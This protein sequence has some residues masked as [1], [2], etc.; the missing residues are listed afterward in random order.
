[1]TILEEPSAINYVN[2]SNHTLKIQTQ[3]ESVAKEETIEKLSVK[4]MQYFW[5]PLVEEFASN[6]NQNND[7]SLDF[8]LDLLAKIDRFVDKEIGL[9]NNQSYDILLPGKSNIDAQISSVGT[10]S[11]TRFQSTGI[12]RTHTN[13]E[14]MFMRQQLSLDA[15]VRNLRSG[16]GLQTNYNQFANGAVSDYEIACIAAPKLLLTRNIILEPSL[17]LKLGARYANADKLQQLSFIEMSPSDIRQVQIDS[18]MD[19]GRRIFYKDLDFG[20]GIQ[21]PLF[22]INAQIENAFKHFD[23]AFGNQ[24]QN[25]M[26]R[27]L[28]NWT[29]S[30]GTQYASRNEKMRLSPYVI[31]SKMGAN[32]QYYSGLQFNFKSIQLGASYGSAQQY[33]F[34]AGLIGKNCALLLQSARQQLFSLNTP[35]YTHQVSFRIYSQPSRKARRY[36]SL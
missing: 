27:A 17:R 14:Q 11:Q 35:S 12:L 36:I 1:M 19:I 30:I 8:N 20:F 25:D 18:T 9:S 4:R 5:T 21:T 26:Q 15:Y 7:K 13:T 34:A 31:Y 16:I 28:Q 22:F 29:I 10:L 24:I 23:Y 2:S 3:Q 33:Q 6:D 32:Q